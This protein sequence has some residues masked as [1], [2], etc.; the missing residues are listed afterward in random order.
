ML[1]PQP[2][3]INDNTEKKTKYTV[4]KVDK[5]TE[6]IDEKGVILL[7]TENY[8]TMFLTDLKKNIQL[9]L[10]VMKYPVYCSVSLI[11]ENHQIKNK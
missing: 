10:F 7:I 4:W 6:T 3:T 1:N 2:G 5:W 11:P 8:A 9:M